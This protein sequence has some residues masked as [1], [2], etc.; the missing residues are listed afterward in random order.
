VCDLR[1]LVAREERGA[2]PHLLGVLRDVE[3]AH[4][5]VVTIR[6]ERHARLLGPRLPPEKELTEHGDVLVVLEDEPVMIERPARALRP[7]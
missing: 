4:H 5:D 6:Q 3:R 7:G 2:A 1:V